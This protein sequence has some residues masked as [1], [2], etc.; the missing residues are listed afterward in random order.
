MSELPSSTPDDTVLQF[1]TDSWS[2][3]YRKEG[4]IWGDSPSEVAHILVN[5]LSPASRILEIGFGYGRDLKLLLEHGH[6]LTGVERSTVGLDMAASNLENYFEGGQLHLVLGDFIKAN[7]S[8]NFYDAAYSHRTIHLLPPEK[9]NPF[10][11]LL[12][13]FISK[14]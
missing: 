11:R 5:N 14:H 9:I 7:L 3:R 10:I 13:F 8:Q 6:T 4:K 1:K 12:S 2:K